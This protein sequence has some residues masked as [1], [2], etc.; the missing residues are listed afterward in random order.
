[1]VFSRRAFLLAERGSKVREIVI[2]GYSKAEFRRTK[3]KLR[4]IAR[5]YLC[6]RNKSHKGVYY[7]PKEN[8]AN[9][10]E[11]CF[12]W[13]ET[14]QHYSDG[15]IKFKYYICH[16]CLALLEGVQERSVFNSIKA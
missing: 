15:D 10:N 7:D 12:S 13:I 5:C 1:V 11:L 6:K 16:E 9:A 8:G 14:I 3:D 2:T 4:G